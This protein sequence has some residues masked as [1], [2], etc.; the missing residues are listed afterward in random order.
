MASQGIPRFIT[1]ALDR[2]E[3][4]L[5]V[6]SG[7]SLPYA[8]K[9]GMPGSLEVST[10]IADRL[11]ERKVSSDESLMQVAQEAVWQDGGSRQRLEATLT[12]AFADPNV[13]PLPAHQALAAIDST[14]ITTNYDTLIERAFQTFGKRLSVVWND[15]HLSSVSGSMLIKV[16]GTVDAPSSCVITEDDY[17]HWMDREPEL[18]ELIRALFLTKTLCFVGYS[19]AD[20]NFRAILRILRF[21]FAAIRRPGLVVTYKTDP[22]SYNHRFITESLGLRVHQGDATD[23]LRMLAR[24]GDRTPYADVLAS[25][26]IRDRYFAEDL[27]DITFQDFAADMIAQQIANGTAEKLSMSPSLLVR[28]RK[29]NDLTTLPS[30]ALSPAADDGFIRVPAG[31]FIAGGER[32][33]NEL[34]RVETIAKPYC[35]GE[36]VVTNDEYRKFVQ[37]CGGVNHDRTHCHPDEPAGKD[38]VPQDEPHPHDLPPDYWISESC[39]DYPVV[40]VDWWDAY[41][42]CRWAGG[43]LPTELE[44]ERAA[45]GVD[46]RQYPWGDSF[47]PSHCN[48]EERGERRTLPVDSLPL[49]R[50]PVGAYQMSG[51]VWEWCA[52]EY[53]SPRFQSASRIVRG[54]SFSR[55]EHRARCAFRN[56]RPPGDAWCSRG[57][58]IARDDS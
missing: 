50:S 34:I 28:L 12:E 31:P 33:G 32:H 47:D 30:M 51:N 26:E 55:G 23:F 19:L 57:F 21:K 4:L 44:W 24:H 5:F 8:G 40:N 2:D 1:E 25:Q 46:G 58:R 22:T 53:F 41:A 13:Q 52:D 43:R 56:G 36:C 38:H 20:P 17:Y 11:L 15:E 27:D 35:I 37:W 42:Y 3:L 48:T 9:K 14:I 10:R 16:H 54:G 45:R 18:R 7:I 29:R 39:G 6:G 49:G